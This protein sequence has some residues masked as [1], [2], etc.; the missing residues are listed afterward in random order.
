MFVLPFT[1]AELFYFLNFDIKVQEILQHITLF[2]LRIAKLISL[3]MT[4]S[5]QNVGQT[6]LTRYS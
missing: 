6:L 2:Y 1:R 3:I 5:V 4:Y